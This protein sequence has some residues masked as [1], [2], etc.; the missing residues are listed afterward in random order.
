MVRTGVDVF[1]VDAVK[2][3]FTFFGVVETLSQFDDGA[4]A[5]TGST[6][7]RYNSF[8]FIVDI[9][10]DTLQNLDSLVGRV[11]ELNVFELD[12]SRQFL[13]KVLATFDLHPWHFIDNVRETVRGTKE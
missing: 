11:S 6:A 13:G 8:S 4:F 12:V 2:Q 7:K 5:A 3:H 1:Q 10:V 9:N